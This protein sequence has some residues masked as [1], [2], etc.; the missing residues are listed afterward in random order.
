MEE[1]VSSGFKPIE[2]KKFLKENY[3]VRFQKGP[4]LS[5]AQTTEERAAI[6]IGSRREL[7][8]DEFVIEK[9]KGAELRMHAPVAQEVALV[10]DAPEE[11]NTSAYYT[12]FADGDRFR[13]YYR[14]AHADEKTKKPT[15]PEFTCYAESKDGIRWEKPKLRLFEF[16][17][18]KENNIVWSGPGTHN[19]TPFKDGNPQV[20]LPVPLQGPRRR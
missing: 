20:A 4:D 13:M 5:D 16:N 9:L 10:C 7:F 1:I 14:G 8:V 3:F 18:S 17:G 6:D 15:H 11:G 19:F 12:L 2:E